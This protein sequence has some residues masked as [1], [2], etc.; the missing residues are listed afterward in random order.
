MPSS[1]GRI[2]RKGRLSSDAIKSGPGEPLQQRRWTGCSLMW[3]RERGRVAN[4]ALAHDT[5]LALTMTDAVAIHPC[6]GVFY[7]VASSIITYGER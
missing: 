4:E 2:P 3:L 6:Y 5:K 1:T 7:I